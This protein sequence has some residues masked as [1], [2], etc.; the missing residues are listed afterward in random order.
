MSKKKREIKRKFGILKET[1]LR[2]SIEQKK[3][4][5]KKGEVGKVKIEIQRIHPRK[6]PLL[7]E[8]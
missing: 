6:R 8:L 3:A 4:N 5:L 2:E 7:K 1:K